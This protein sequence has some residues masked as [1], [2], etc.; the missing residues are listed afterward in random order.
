MTTVKNN[1]I[2][3]STESLG[4][5]VSDGQAYGLEERPESVV[6]DLETCKDFVQDLANQ[7]QAM[8]EA[9]R[10][11]KEDLDVCLAD[12]SECKDPATSD[13]DY[14]AMAPFG[15]E[16]DR[17]VDDGSYETPINGPPMVLINGDSHS[18]SDY[19]EVSDVSDPSERSP[20]S[21]GYQSDTYINISTYEM[22]DSLQS[23]TNNTKELDLKTGG[24]EN[25]DDGAIYEF[26][27]ESSGE[28]TAPQLDKELSPAEKIAEE[29]P[30]AEFRYD[31]PLIFDEDDKKEV[32][33]VKEKDKVKK[34]NPVSRNHRKRVHGV[35]HSSRI[36]YH[37]SKQS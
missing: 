26:P 37:A 36:Q 23:L 10:K 7:V 30:K 16:Q 20:L 22:T 11:S 21:N 33:K 28:M 15:N 29:L 3:C 13:E 14:L 25:V 19:E 2:V 32:F 4:Q 17:V 35:V 9:L 18:Q 1:G 8:Q 27:P 24:E 34:W 6:T 31:G 12:S 5:T